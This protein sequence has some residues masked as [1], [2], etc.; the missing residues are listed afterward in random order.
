V[1][2]SPEQLDASPVDERRLCAWCRET[3]PESA[4]ADSQF[5]KVSCRQS[6]FR[7]R[8]RHNGFDVPL[9]GSGPLVFAYAD[10]PYPG[11]AEKYYADQPAYAGEVDH[12]RLCATLTTR[13]LAKEIAGF[14]LS[15][16]ARSLRELLPMLPAG[17]RVC[18]W[19]KPIGT[20]STTYGAHNTWE[21]L[22]V[23]G[24]RPTRSG[25]RDFLIAQPARRGG[26]LPGRK[27]IAFCA[28]L[29]QLLGMQPDDTLDD[30][31]PGTGVVSRAWA[32]LSRRP[33]TPDASSAVAERVRRRPATRRPSSSDG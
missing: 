15:T 24:G 9:V 18:S 4:R 22:I 7:L 26:D 16:S 33:S 1:N 29:F 3:I 32:S 19:V 10:P 27:P 8:R 31:F 21:P 6:A 17:A 30:L 5:C 2:R 13:W 23:C 11:T 20:P 12:D 25:V 14:G 28:W